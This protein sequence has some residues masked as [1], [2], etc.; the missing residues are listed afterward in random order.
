MV[1]R[2]QTAPARTD[3]RR[4]R[5]R[6]EGL[7]LLVDSAGRLPSFLDAATHAR[8]TTTLLA[9]GTPQEHRDADVA[10]LATLRATLLAD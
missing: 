3:H 9:L 6:E 2:A 10:L 8:A 1:A 4:S 5:L 7:L